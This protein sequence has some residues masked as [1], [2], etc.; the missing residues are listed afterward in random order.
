MTRT[1]NHSTAA[2]TNMPNGSFGRVP[3]F[4]LPASFHPGEFLKSPKL[5]ARFDDA[6]YFVSLILRKLARWDVDHLGL[7]RLHAKH[8]RNMMF[9]ADYAAVVEALVDGGAVERFPYQVGQR[10]F[11][12][13]LAA[14]FIA[15]KHVRVPIADQ[16]LIR[17]LEKF[18][19]DCAQERLVRMK[20]VHHAL[21]ERQLRL[22]IHGDRAREVL[23]GLPQAENPFDCQGVLVGDI[24]ARDFH[25]AVGNYGRVANNITSLKRELRDELHVGGRRLGSVDL[26]CAQPAFVAKLIQ[27]AAKGVCEVSASN[28]NQEAKAQIPGFLRTETEGKSTGELTREGA[29]RAPDSNYDSSPTIRVHYDSS[30][31]ATSNS[32]FGLYRSLVQRGEFY[33]HLL[34]EL[35]HAI[36]R[37]ELKRR[38]LADVIAKRKASF[39]GGE[40]PSI[41]EAKF[42]ELFPTV[43]R[44]I[45]S[46]N[47]NGYEH[48]NLIRRL[49]RAESALVI[50]TVAADLLTRNPRMFCLTLHDAIYTTA[51]NLA[52]VEEAFQRA[53]E[54]TGFAMSFKTSYPDGRP[55]PAKRRTNGCHPTVTTSLQNSVTQRA[56]SPAIL[57]PTS[58]PPAASKPP[59]N[60]YRKLPSIFAKLTTADLRDDAT[61][62]DWFHAAIKRKNP[63]VSDAD[64][65]NVFAAAERALEVGGNPPALFAHIVSEHQWQFISCEQE[66]RARKRLVALRRAQRDSPPATRPQSL[67]ALVNS[68]LQRP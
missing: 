3:S 41:V 49:Q 19:D 2:A 58:P 27:D 44:F 59:E 11:G 45:R 1:N 68:F 48:A 24:E 30:R 37:D 47:C 43:Y 22:Q 42:R 17:R 40:Y 13:R 56:D 55:T 4:V 21:A 5:Q 54:Q 9:Q 32:D 66:D 64:R 51:E 26:S 10:S 57:S 14:R 50:E 12:Y 6:R 15:D 39:R 35:G 38:F 62:L 52:N 67:G 16:R 61:L 28:L 46:V 29:Q 23:S 53:F 18:S 8:L 20:P 34:G 65:L 63:V 31:P 25:L 33:D 36:S 7:V 60:S